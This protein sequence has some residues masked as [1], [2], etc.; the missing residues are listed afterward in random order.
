MINELRTWLYNQFL[1]INF[2][3]EDW[4]TLLTVLT[5]IIIWVIVGYILK[6]I[7]AFYFSRLLNRGFRGKDD[8]HAKTI[9]K[10]VSNISTFVLVIF[11]A[12]IIMSELGVDIATIIAS[13]GIVGL[14]VGFGA[15]ELIKDLI[16]GFFIIAE[17]IFSVGE[18][19][20]YGD[21]RGT[22]VNIGLRTTIIE[23]VYNETLIVN[24]SDIR[25]VKNVARK[26]SVGI[27]DFKIAYGT[28]LV[29]FSDRFIDYLNSISSKYDQ[30]IGVPSF[31][32]V[33]D[34]TAGGLTLRVRFTCVNGQHFALSRALLGDIYEYC[35]K[36]NIGLPGYVIKPKGE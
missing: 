7:L 17:K 30:M 22:V 5:M 12:I 24:N 26:N 9:A 29:H 18:V 31:Y 23:N 33:A 35:M 20:I 8:K 4:A 34:T 19:I 15:Q 36:H 21:F 14:A 28:D 16:S 6:R 3:N 10:M 2:I 32:G 27:V 25:A 11:L 1:S 13:A